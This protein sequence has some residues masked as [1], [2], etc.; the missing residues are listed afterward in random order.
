MVVRASGRGVLPNEWIHREQ[1]ESHAQGQ[2]CSHN[3]WISGTFGNLHEKATI[4]AGSTLDGRV[5]FVKVR[6]GGGRGVR[7]EGFPGGG[8]GRSEEARG[9]S[10][11]V[12]PAMGGGVIAAPLAAQKPS[13]SN[14]GP[15]TAAT[16]SMIAT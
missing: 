11:F 15:P 8:L 14:A 1:V 7:G 10:G 4:D 16:G 13:A 2:D 5:A 3:V 9:C 12:A 6:R